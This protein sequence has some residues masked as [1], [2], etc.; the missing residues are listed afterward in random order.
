MP[1]SCIARPSKIYP[2]WHFWFENI[3]SGNTG[4]YAGRGC[5][6]NPVL[7]IT[8]SLGF[9]YTMLHPIPPTHLFSN[10]IK[11]EILC[12]QKAMFLTR[13]IVMSVSFNLFCKS[14]WAETKGYCPLTCTCL[15]R[16]NKQKTLFNMQDPI[17]R[18][19]N[20]QL[21]RQRCSRL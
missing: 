1:T 13:M 10:I 18:L 8:F 20:L 12:M 14:L 19:L 6:R 9:R 11:S 4:V 17:L 16:D 21:Q 15:Q 3:P 7:Q 5:L 2:I